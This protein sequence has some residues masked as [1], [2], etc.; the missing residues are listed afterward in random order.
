[1]HKVILRTAAGFTLVEILVSVLLFSSALVGLV[2]VC[3][4][5]AQ[6]GQRAEKAYVAY[7]LAKNRIESL[8]HLSFAELADAE[9]EETVI[10]ASGTP[11]LGGEYLRTTTVTSN[12]SGSANLASVTVEVSYV[13]RGQQSAQPIEMTSVIYSGG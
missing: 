2:S 9:E 13:V 10:D 12:Y 11:D 5:G 7:N 8:K 1:M 4:S 6:M 3:L